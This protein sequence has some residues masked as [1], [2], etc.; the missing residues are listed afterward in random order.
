MDKA[1]SWVKCGNKACVRQE[2]EASVPALP[3]DS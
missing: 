3:K 1:E 2:T